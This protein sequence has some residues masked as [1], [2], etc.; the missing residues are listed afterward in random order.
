MADL[1]TPT[2]T[3]QTLLAAVPALAQYLA[4]D[5]AD[6][7]GER[8]EAW[9]R[10]REYVFARGLD[11]DLVVVAAPVAPYLERVHLYRTA[12]VIYENVTGG[13]REEAAREATRFSALADQLLGVLRFGADE[14][15]N[16]VLDRGE[17]FVLPREFAR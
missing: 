16:G 2:L 10:L 6:F 1:V 3:E 9:A 12:A 13:G 8:A 14:N 7:S 11:P 15:G 4:P 17:A 5:R